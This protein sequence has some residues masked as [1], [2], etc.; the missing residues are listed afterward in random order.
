MAIRVKV[1]L[2]ITS[3]VVMITTLSIG[4]SIFFAQQHILKTIEKD[5][6]LVAALGDELVSGKINLLK[7]NAAI[8]AQVLSNVSDEE[9]PMVL[10]EQVEAYE[11][12]I[13]ITIFNPQG[14][15]RAYGEIPTPVELMNKEYIQRAFAGDMVMS[16]TR[17]TPS[18][19]VV[20]HICVPM[21][22][23]D[24]I[25]S[26]TIPGMIFSDFLSQFKIWE[27]GHFFIDDREGTVIANPRREWVLQRYNF[28][29]L[30]KTNSQYQNIAHIVR[31]M[32]QGETGIG[33]FSLNEVERLCAFM[34]I[35]GSQV[36]WS[37]G[38]I[39]PLP[40]SPFIQV[41]QTFLIAAAIFFGLG[42]LAAFFTSGSIARPFQQIQE[43][44]HRLVELNEIALNA[45]KAKSTFLAK[46]SHE[47]RTPLNAII[48]FS[49]LSLGKK[50]LPAPIGENLEKMYNS[51]MTL[52]GIVNDLLDISK[53]ES[54]KF[55]IIPA[56]YDL[57]SLINDTINLNIIRIG[58]KPITFTLLI[59]ETLPSRLIGDELRIKQIFNNL[60]SNAFKYTNEGTVE[61]RISTEQEG[62]TVWLTAAVRDSGI[63]IKPEDREKLFTDYSR[64][65][66]KHNRSLEGTGLGL[67]LTKKIVEFMEGRISLES[68]YGKGSTF[69]VRF[70]QQ[71]VNAE[72][73]GA[74]TAENLKKCSYSD[75]KRSRNEGLVRIH[76]PY[77]K[78]LVVD[79]V[80]VNLD[81]ARGMLSPYGMQVDCASGGREAVEIIREEA[82][83]YDAIFMDHMM[84][85]I[86]G[87][88]A[89]RIIREEIGTE[90]AKTIPVIVLTANAIVGNE[91]MFLRHGFQDFLSKPIDIMR[92]DGVI[93]RWVRNKTREKEQER[94]SEQELP[95]GGTPSLAELFR[96]IDGLDISKLL[97]LFKG[98]E[99][100]L[101]KLFRSYIVY[102]RSQLD[103]LSVPGPE[104]LERYAETVHGIKGASYN[105]GA[106]KV[107]RQA[108]NLEGA[109]RQG[110]MDFIGGNNHVFILLLKELLA[111]LTALLDQNGL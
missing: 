72:P 48:G 78:V 56:E 62:D 2:L 53:I 33:R 80:P 27:T 34:P 105:I 30:A 95:V 104:Q 63:G 68:E 25:I 77:A 50:D 79:D 55:E 70:R 21:A 59:D 47:M 67:A 65:D 98:N 42:I 41:Q 58:S 106:N 103:K 52:L 108:E 44:N 46:M 61:W 8:A 1:F 76:C 64:L 35:T 94:A 73:I 83:H 20:F 39:A 17:Q 69:T 111:D 54:G 6:L 37:L 13:A 45:S 40:E 89:L 81:V 75:Q 28:I 102:I 97:N 23:D 85:E 26:V 5:M 18:G 16:T 12:F 32:I 101:P 87:I 84:P 60:L 99:K 49:E 82:V 9:L 29:E 14:I 91:E 110:N 66:M 74:A 11:D 43:Q 38:V 10:Q 15:V 96:G 107:G 36:G 19:E 3:I 22:M 71:S 100:P 24:R 88:E 109:A 57:P 90:Y 86:D 4:I 93:H 7:A 92:L 51:G 31:R